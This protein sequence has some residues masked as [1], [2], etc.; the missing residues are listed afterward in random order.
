MRVDEGVIFD[1]GMNDGRDT[2]Y[3]VSKGYRVV[4]IEADPTLA[5]LAQERFSDEIREG[6]VTVVNV[7]IADSESTATFWVNEL[8]SEHSS[9]SK[10]EGGR[11]GSPCHPIEVRTCRLRQLLETYGVPYYIKIDI[12]RY[13]KYCLE[14]LDPEALPV[15]VSIEAHSLSYLQ[16]LAELGCDRFKAPTKALMECRRDA[17]RMKPP[18]VGSTER[19]GTV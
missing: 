4:A 1:V 5:E 16:R 18:S 8:N 7:G 3:Y 13:D 19:S 15:Y 6:L 2:A 11:D 17:A 14:D 12:E 10:E 9:F